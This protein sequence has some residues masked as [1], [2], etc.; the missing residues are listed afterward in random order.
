M[1]VSGQLKV[2]GGKVPGPY[3]IG[4]WVGPRSDLDVVAKKKSLPLP[5]IETRSSNT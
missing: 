2:L 4:D 1:E 3:F 5:G